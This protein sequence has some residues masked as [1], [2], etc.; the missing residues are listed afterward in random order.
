MSDQG[1]PP[2][3]EQSPTACASIGMCASRWTTASRCS[4]TSTDR[5]RGRYPAILSATGRTPRA[6]R[7]RR[8]YAPQ[9]DKMVEDFP[10]VA[11]GST[12]KYQNWEVVDPEKWVPDGYAC[13]RVDSRGHG[14]LA[15]LSR[16][17][18]AA[19]DARLLRVHRVG[20]ARS[21]GASGKVGL[22]GHLLL[23]DEPVAGRRARSRRTSPR[24]CPWEGCDRLVPRVL[25][26]TAGSS[27]H[28]GGEVVPDAGLDRPA[29][30]RR[31]R[32]AQPRHRRARGRARRR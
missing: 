24:S 14:L 31:A 17:V 20:R 26:T 7:S 8:R 32:A 13:V 10:E 27:P 5:R 21:P 12:N 30:R 16:P 25:A 18:V 1:A 22:T 28:F 3:R 29:R 2:T 6:S 23:R 19:R 9:W 11:A 4:P 15:G